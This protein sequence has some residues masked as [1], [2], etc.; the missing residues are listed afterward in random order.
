MALTRLLN[1]L[2]SQPGTY[3]VVLESKSHRRI[4]VGKL[5]RL[6]LLPGFY[7]YVGSAFGPGGVAA[8]VARHMRRIKHPHWHIDYLRPHIHPRE[9]WYS[10]SSIRLECRWAAILQT[11]CGSRTVATGLGSSD[12]SC[13]THLFYFANRPFPQILPNYLGKISAAG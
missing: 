5:G 8:R 11:A 13:E 7:V 2:D 9:I 1:R 12:C 6:K 10:F 3:A 4:R